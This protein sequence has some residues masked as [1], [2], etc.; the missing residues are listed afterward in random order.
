MPIV[1]LLNFNSLTYN[2]SSTSSIVYISY[3]HY[4]VLLPSSRR[5]SSRR[6]Q[7]FR[8]HANN[9]ARTTS[10][11][12]D[13]YRRS[14]RNTFFLTFAWTSGQHVTPSLSLFIPLSLS[15]STPSIKCRVVSQLNSAGQPPSW[16]RPS[17]STTTT[18]LIVVVLF[19]TRSTRSCWNSRSPTVESHANLPSSSTLR[20]SHCNCTPR[21]RSPRGQRSHQLYSDSTCIHGVI[22]YRP[23]RR[24]SRWWEWW[25]GRMWWSDQLDCSEPLCRDDHSFRLVLF[26]W[27]TDIRNDVVFGCSS[28]SFDVCIR[29]LDAQE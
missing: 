26:R 2:H 8:C 4:R 28:W 3:R 18:F 23:E 16:C 6:R 22:L 17:S 5:S 20:I 15:L 21:R 7:R 10:R 25:W 13:C 27:W 11:A 14:F 24:S 1:F 29:L 19:V 12:D 9:H